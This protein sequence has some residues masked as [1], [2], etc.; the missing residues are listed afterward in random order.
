MTM[1]GRIELEMHALNLRMG[2]LSELVTLILLYW[3]AKECESLHNK[4]ASTTQ[5]SLQNGS[6][7]T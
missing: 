5:T 4:A 6:P 7:G 1:M 2:P 3:L